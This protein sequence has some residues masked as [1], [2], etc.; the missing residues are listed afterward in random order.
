MRII[1]LEYQEMSNQRKVISIL[2]ACTIIPI[3]LT[4]HIHIA[5]HQKDLSKSNA[6]SRFKGLRYVSKF[7]V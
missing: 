4:L 2:N 5:I 7:I 3:L 6:D 1:D